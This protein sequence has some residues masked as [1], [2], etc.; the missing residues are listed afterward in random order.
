MPRST[1]RHGVPITT[2]SYLTIWPTGEGRPVSTLNS[3]NGRIKANA[4]P[5]GTSS[6]SVSVFVTNTTN[7]V[8]TSVQQQLDAK[9][10]RAD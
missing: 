7:V 1:Q 8:S 2:L 6:G 3:L 4:V 10:R 5:S 9:Q